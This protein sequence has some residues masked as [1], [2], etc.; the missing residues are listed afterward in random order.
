M[1]LAE[2][3]AYKLIEKEG[4]HAIVL[5]EDR[6]AMH[7]A[8][9]SASTI[10]ALGELV[11]WYTSPKQAAHMR[12]SAARALSEIGAAP[13]NDN[14][15]RALSFF[16]RAESEAAFRT[17]P[18]MEDECD[19]EALIE[20]AKGH[21]SSIAWTQRLG[22]T[23]QVP[24]V[25]QSPAYTA[26]SQVIP[27]T[28]SLR[29]APTASSCPALATAPCLTISDVGERL[30]NDRTQDKSWD[31][32]MVR[33]ARM[34]V[35]LFDRFLT[36]ERRISDLAALSL[37]DIDA[38]DTFLRRMGKSYGKAPADKARSIAD[39][40]KRWAALPAS[41]VGLEGK[42]RNKHFSFLTSCWLGHGKPVLLSTAI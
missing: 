19:F 36:D 35:D 22:E 2:G 6:E 21:V 14:I 16:A 34:I 20:R 7:V 28:D 4:L 9:L 23:T 32:K 33:Q 8:G 15:D 29:L 30:I 25:E 40:R 18:Q 37:A 17:K 10:D 38:F 42:T 11:E 39:L 27:K 12:F 13:T 5:P 1:R 3:W 24:P 31:D 41:T 26:D